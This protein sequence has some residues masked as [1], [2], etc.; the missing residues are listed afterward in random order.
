MSERTTSIMVPKRAHTAVVL[1]ILVTSYMTQTMPGIIAFDHC[2]INTQT[3]TIQASK[4]R[5]QTQTKTQ[6]Q[7]RDISQQMLQRKAV[8]LRLRC[9]EETQSDSDS[10]SDPEAESESVTLRLRGGGLPDLPDKD[11]ADTRPR[12]ISK[13]RFVASHS[14]LARYESP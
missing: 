6:T 10:E 1:C 13:A 3:Q 8:T 12:G 7:S 14:P 4:T 11:N 2:H 9:G 5:I